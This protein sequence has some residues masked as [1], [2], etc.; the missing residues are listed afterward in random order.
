MQREREGG[1]MAVVSSVHWARSCRFGLGFCSPYCF[2]SG[3]VEVGVREGVVCHG[4]NRHVVCLMAEK[5]VLK[6]LSEK[7]ESCTLPLLN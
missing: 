7:G 6:S 2:S 4:E 5:E 1:T 3:M